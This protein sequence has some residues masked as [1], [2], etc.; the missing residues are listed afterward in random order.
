MDWSTVKLAADI[1][2]K[3][4]SVRKCAQFT[5]NQVLVSL[6]KYSRASDT[7][8]RQNQRHLTGFC[9]LVL[10]LQLN[11]A[12]FMGSWPPTDLRRTDI[13]NGPSIRLEL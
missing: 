3:P 1:A 13:R 5:Q 9:K 6:T 11:W 10:I 2:G 4:F 8:L 12:L 7:R